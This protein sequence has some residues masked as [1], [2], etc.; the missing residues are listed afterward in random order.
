M[1]IVNIFVADGTA[2]AIWADNNNV[3]DCQWLGEVGNDWL[4]YKAKA[5]FEDKLNCSVIINIVADG[6]ARTTKGNLM[7]I[8]T[9]ESTASYLMEHGYGEDVLVMY[10]VDELEYLIAGAQ[11]MGAETRATAGIGDPDIDQ[12]IT[13]LQQFI[14]TLVIEID[15][16][17]NTIDAF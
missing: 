13:E 4:N 1:I 14:T 11:V 17:N 16:R 6:I 15:K 12:Y 9:A 5:Y 10:T 7:Q 3:E 8:E 2:D